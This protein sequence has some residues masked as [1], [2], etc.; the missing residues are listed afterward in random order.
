MSENGRHSKDPQI[1]L[2]QLAD[3]VIATSPAI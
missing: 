3:E 2:D 1:M